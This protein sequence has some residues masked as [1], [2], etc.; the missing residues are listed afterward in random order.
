MYHLIRQEGE[1]LLLKFLGKTFKNLSDI[2][3]LMKITRGNEYIIPMK[4]IIQHYRKRERNA[5]SKEYI[6][7]LSAL[8]FFYGSLGLTDVLR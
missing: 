3:V 8:I 2:D 6:D 1:V 5:L 7:D 4:S